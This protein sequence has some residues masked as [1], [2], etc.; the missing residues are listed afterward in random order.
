MIIKIFGRPFAWLI[1]INLKKNVLKNGL[2]KKGASSIFLL[3]HEV[4]SVKHFVFN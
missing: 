2:S 3:Y 4:N 1:I